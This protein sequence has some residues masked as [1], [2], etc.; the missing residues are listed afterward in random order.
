MLAYS[1]TSQLTL[2]SKAISQRFF[3]IAMINAVLGK[4][5]GELME[6]RRLI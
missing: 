3:F 5:T 1:N 4:D 6:Y 2:T